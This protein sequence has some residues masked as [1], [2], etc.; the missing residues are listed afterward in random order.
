MA[1]IFLGQSQGTRKSRKG[2]GGR[3]R[4]RERIGQC[5]VTE[6]AT[7]TSYLVQLLFYSLHLILLV[8]CAYC[9]TKGKC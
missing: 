3:E 8:D 2:G 5:V 6:S 1:D 9:S 7:S 4:E